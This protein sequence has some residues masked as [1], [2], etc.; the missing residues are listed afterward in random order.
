[1]SCRV[2]ITLG[3]QAGIGPEIVR[4]A[5][6]SGRLPTDAQYSTIGAGDAMHAGFAIAR[7]VRGFDFAQAVR[8]GQAAAAASV[9]SPDGTRG[10]TAALIERFFVE[11]ARQ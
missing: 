5:L 6:A 4:A 11:L 7:W 9:N 10:V 1:M 8:Y 3:D 2:G